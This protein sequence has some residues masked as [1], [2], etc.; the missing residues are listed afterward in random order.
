MAKE[1]KFPPVRFAT[2]DR[3]DISMTTKEIIEHV[4]SYIDK[5]NQ[6][7]EKRLKKRSV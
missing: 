1:Y 2:V 4:H 5:K 7:F 3:P 6:E